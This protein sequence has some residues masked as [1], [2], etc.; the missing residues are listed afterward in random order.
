[1][2]DTG[3]IHAVGILLKARP[4][5]ETSAILHF[6]TEDHGVIAGYLRGGRL[7][8][9]AA[10]GWT[11]A[12]CDVER[13]A[14]SPGQLGLLKAE[15]IRLPEIA[16]HADARLFGLFH[17]VCDLVAGILPPYAP[18]PVMFRKLQAWLSVSRAVDFMS[19]TLVFLAEGLKMSGYAPDWEKCAVT[20][21][22]E[23]LIYVSPKTG[24]AVCA[25]IGAPY[26]EKLFPLPAFLTGAGGAVTIADYDNG[27]RL[28]LFC[29]EK[30]ILRPTDKN[31]PPLL[32]G[33]LKN[34]AYDLAIG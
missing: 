8:K 10:T 3:L 26:R 20:G 17:G 27:L 30:F 9:N 7:L 6:L 31:L 16:F 21:V 2:T 32:R 11:G 4:H 34:T 22:H 12:V 25:E 18:D 1:M 5:G 15:L 24:A 23:N 28:L 29:Y 33:F 13:Y 14:R 19:E